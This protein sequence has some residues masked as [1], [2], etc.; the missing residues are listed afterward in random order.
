ML[1]LEIIPTLS[2]NYTYLLWKDPTAACL[3]D[4]GEPTQPLTSLQK[5]GLTLRWILNTHHHADH[6]DGNRV[7]H[8]QTGAEILGLS[9]RIPG[10]QRQLMAEE[11]LTLGGLQLQTIA[12]PGHTRD[13]ACFYVPEKP[14]YLF[15]GDTLFVGG[16]GR[17]FE[18]TAADLWH[19][20][21]RLR[22]LPS[23]TRVYAGHEYTSENFRFACAQEP[24]NTRLQTR[25]AHLQRQQETLQTTM[26]STLGEEVATNLFFNA[27]D[28]QRLGKLR[29]L[30]NRF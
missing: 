21:Q 27:P 1:N 28:A 13:S 19:S 24:Q 30:K 7:L 16:C 12:T 2:D 15:T 17:L 3:I 10:L 23:E 25:A 8:A 4:P 20:F 22:K 5:Q 26:P 29:E 11:T 14:G 9:P 6:T 18:G